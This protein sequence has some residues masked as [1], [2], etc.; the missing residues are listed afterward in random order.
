VEYDDNQTLRDYAITGRQ[1]G[2][3]LV[4]VFEDWYRHD[5]GAVSIR[6]FE[7]V[8]AQLVHKVA[9]DCYSSD[10]CNRYLVV[11]HNGD[12]FPCDFFVRPEYRL[13]NI[14]EHSFEEMRGS[15]AYQAFA[16]GKQRWGDACGTCEFL[17]LCMGDCP[18]FRIPAKTGAGRTSAL[19]A[20]W[21][22]FYGQTL[23]RF[24]R[25]ADRL[26]PGGHAG[27]RYAAL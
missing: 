23:D 26:T 12:V 27:A 21:K 20:G 9:V 14:L 3:F 6:L 19:C 5:I 16:A 18:K 8:L 1:W 11:E 10:A 17:L 2:E 13:G 24:Q 22:A 15:D 25:L 4:A 7:S